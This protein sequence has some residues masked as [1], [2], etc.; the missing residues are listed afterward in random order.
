MTATPT[1]EASRPIPS[2]EAG[3]AVDIV[4]VRKD[5]GA[6]VG[7]ADVSLTIGKGEFV[8]L[9][10]PSGCGK[11]TLLGMI[12]GFVT[13]T[14]G[15]IVVD[16][17]DITDL[18]PYRRDIGMVFQSYAL[19]PHMNVYD[20]IAFGLKMRKLP[21]AQIE[22]EVR[23]AI[24][25]MKLDGFENRRVR[26]LSG[27][28]QQR[29][30]LARAIVIRPKVLLLDEPLS[31][32]D[33]NLRAQMQVE[34]S[35]LHRKTGLTTI[36]VTHDQGEAL[37]LSDRIVVMNKGS[38][39]QVAA[40][41]ELYR[42]PANGFVASFIGEINALPPGRCEV[43]GGTASLVLPGIGPLAFPVAPATGFAPGRQVRAFLRLE[44]VR[45]VL[46]GEAG[47]NVVTGTVEAHIYQGSHTITRV[48]VEGIG[49]IETRVTGADIVAAAPVG[50]SLALAVDL[51]E[52]VLLDAAE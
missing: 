17:A 13:P 12:A 36:F 10:G 37:S 44:H 52:A 47:P 9:L 35:E 34:L 22:A 3:S 46:G 30:A 18:E 14:A 26:Q 43:N 16:G 20:N 51:S 41:V 6:A 25:M 33:K 28:Q 4:R 32:L 42:R 23:R 27:G 24:G 19:F 31:A 50:A 11:S 45:P 1:Q 8:T 39:Q 15:K 38:V 2:Q 40:P 21:A 49:L 7:V 5:F 48:V 29:V